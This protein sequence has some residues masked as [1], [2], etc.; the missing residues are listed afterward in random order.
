MMSS[1]LKKKHDF[2]P[3]D[4]VSQTEAARMRRVSRQAISDLVKKM[5]FTTL[6]V[7]GKILLSRSEVE[8][9]QRLPP[10]PVPKGRSKRR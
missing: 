6:S 1:D 2:D 10:G 4:W 9:Y 7:A 3:A 5:R 8:D